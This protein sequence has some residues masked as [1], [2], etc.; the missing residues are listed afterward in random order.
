LT[1]TGPLQV[2]FKTS[3]WGVSWAT[4]LAT[5]ELAD[6]LPI[7][8]SGWLFDHF[9]AIRDRVPT[10]EGV[11]EAMVTAAALAAR[12]RRL[13]FGHTVLGATHRHPALVASMGATID[14]VAGP[15]RFVLGLGAGWLEH[16]HERFG[17]E[18]PP[19]AERI[20][21]LQASV[22]I[23]RGMWREPDGITLEAGPYRVDR[24]R[25][26]P[27][28]VTPGGPP[29]WLGAQGPKGLD[30]IARAADGWNA[31]LPVEAFPD[32]LD[33]LRRRCEAA[34][35]DPDEIEVSAQVMGLDR[36]AAELVD[37]ATRYVRGGARHVIFIIRAS[38]GPDGLLAFIDEVVTPLRERVG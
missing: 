20:E 28:P 34:G 24:A 4:L 6:E 37:E 36:P 22:R 13:R 29:I 5:W 8:D 1:P 16:D 17:W 32:R 26:L 15:G 38:D 27:P 12:T 7:L 10:A 19:V 25:T 2:G 23:I 35:R 30:L 21:R 11:H 14:H 33:L 3:Q 9:T 31:N 18:L